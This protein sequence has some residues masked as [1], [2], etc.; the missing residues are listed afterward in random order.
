[1]SV[2]LFVGTVIPFK[3]YKRVTHADT[4]Y[5]VKKVKVALLVATRGYGITVQ[6]FGTQEGHVVS[7]LWLPS[8]LQNQKSS[9]THLSLV[10]RVPLA[11]FKPLIFV[12]RDKCTDHLDA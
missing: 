7:I 11:G 2:Y 12:M 5:N 10:T 3:T 1:M 6:V 4:T 9:G 8:L